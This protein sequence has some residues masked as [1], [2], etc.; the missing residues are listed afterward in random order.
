M[1]Q[2]PADTACRVR[3]VPLRVAER[4]ACQRFA[5]VAVLQGQ[6]GNSVRRGAHGELAQEVVDAVGVVVFALRGLVGVHS[7]VPATDAGFASRHAE[8]R[9][10]FVVDGDVANGGVEALLPLRRKA[11][12]ALAPAFFIPFGDLLLGHF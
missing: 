2:V 1:I 7:H 10:G 11:R 6:V 3:V 4:V 8:H 12:L 9:A 5:A